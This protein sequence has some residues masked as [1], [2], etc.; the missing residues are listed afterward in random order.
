[1]VMDEGA[2]DAGYKFKEKEEVEES[3][4]AGDCWK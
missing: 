1:M 3:V 2:V 4:S